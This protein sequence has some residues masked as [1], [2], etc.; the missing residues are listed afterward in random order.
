MVCVRQVGERG[1]KG[2]GKGADIPAGDTIV[3][4]EEEEEEEEEG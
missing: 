2:E 4:E 3:E 1:E